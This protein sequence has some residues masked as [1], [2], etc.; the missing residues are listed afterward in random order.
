MIMKHK[1]F[2]IQKFFDCVEN[3]AKQNPEFQKEFKEIIDMLKEKKGRIKA[4][5]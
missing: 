4:V 3:I 2:D 1:N 5:I